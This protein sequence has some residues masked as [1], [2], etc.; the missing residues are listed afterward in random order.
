ME[1]IAGIQPGNQQEHDMTYRNPSKKLKVSLTAIAL[2]T[3]LATGLTYMTHAAT[4][5]AGEANS[6]TAAA[7]AAL[8][9]V[10]TMP[11]EEARLRTWNTF[12]GRL[13][14]VDEA[15]IQPLV[16]GTIQQ[17]LFEDGAYVEAGQELF[18]IDPRPFAA[19]LQAAEANLQS[20]RSEVA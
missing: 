10:Q 12:S 6:A 2:G 15:A 19:E 18:A 4:D 7:P 20:A 14:A 3:M 11:V 8:P 16:S 17:V 5:E 9:V 13:T 1:L